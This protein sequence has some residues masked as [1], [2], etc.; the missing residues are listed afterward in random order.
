MGPNEAQYNTIALMHNIT[1]TSHKYRS[2][3]LLSDLPP[4]E[5][6]L[7]KI[8]QLVDPYNTYLILKTNFHVVSQI[9][10]IIEKGKKQYII[11]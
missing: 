6:N 3:N 5:D 4:S 10:K 11:L 8:Y 7:K 9:A 2:N 1:R